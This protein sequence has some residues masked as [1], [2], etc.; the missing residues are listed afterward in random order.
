MTLV[1]H[2]LQSTPTARGRS[3]PVQAR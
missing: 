2:V 3:S 1:E